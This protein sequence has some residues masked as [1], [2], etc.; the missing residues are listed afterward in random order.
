MKKRIEL[1]DVA[2]AITIFL[3]IMGH[4]TGNLETPMYR[5][6]LYSFHMPLFFFLAGLSIKAVPLY[7][8]NDWRH[9]LRKN[10]RAIV[11]PYFIWGLIYAAFSFKNIGYLFYGSWAALGSMGTLTSLWYLSCLFI[12]R[13]L[14]QIVISAVNIPFKK[15]PPNQAIYGVSGL[16]MIATGLFL[17]YI[18][19][20]YLWCA[21]VAFVAG[22]IILLGISLRRQILIFAQ[23]KTLVL[24]LS[25]IVSLVLFYFGTVFRGDA[26]DLSLMCGSRYGN[27]FWFLYTSLFGSFTV[28]AFSMILCRIAREGARPFS[29]SAVTYIGQRTMGIFLIHKNFL[30]MLIMPFAKKIF[31]EETPILLIVFAASCVAL[32]IS[33]ILCKIIERYM[34]QLLGQFPNEYKNENHPA[35]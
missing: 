22:G 28:L 15:N 3:V 27:K 21:D 4:T 7:S 23:Q 31:P 8:W 32:I 12:A 35:K 30:A 20:G 5:R 11:V 19:G 25:F 13:V 14:I 34:P 29:V 17:P 6:L 26:L 10:I 18:E 16:V 9:F 33:I 1:I 24:V 2:K